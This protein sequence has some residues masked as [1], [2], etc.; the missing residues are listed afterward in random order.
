MSVHAA[1]LAEPKT[2]IGVNASMTGDDDTQ[3][4]LVVEDLSKVD[5]IDVIAGSDL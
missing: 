3:E 2:L 4:Q 1:E 5:C